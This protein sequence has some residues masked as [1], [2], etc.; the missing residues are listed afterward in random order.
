M[1]FSPD[2]EIAQNVLI[3]LVGLDTKPYCHEQLGGIKRHNFKRG[4]ISHGSMSHREPRSIGSGSTSLRAYSG[5][6]MPGRMGGMKMKIRKPKIVKIDNELIVVMIKGVAPGK[7]GNPLRILG[8]RLWAKYT[9][10]L[11]FDC[12]FYVI[13]VLNE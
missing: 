10:K 1:Y 12:S 2:L 5:K 13:C 9:Q 3:C 4:Q 7:P 6:K 11:V 8:Q